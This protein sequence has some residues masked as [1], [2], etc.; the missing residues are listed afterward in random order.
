MTNSSCLHRDG[1][2]CTDE[3]DQHGRWLVRGVVPAVLGAVL[4]DDAG[5]RVDDPLH[6]VCLSLLPTP[7]GGVVQR[8]HSSFS[9]VKE[10]LSLISVSPHWA[11]GRLPSALER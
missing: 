11:L 6:L 7:S 5:G 4:D 3:A 10:N 1:P 2:G 9:G 8:S